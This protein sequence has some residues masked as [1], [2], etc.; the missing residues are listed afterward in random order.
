MQLQR[1]IN[2]DFPWL[3]GVCR[4]WR[5]G[6]VEIVDVTTGKFLS[7]SIEELP[8]QDIC[9]YTDWRCYFHSVDQLGRE[10]VVEWNV[11]GLRNGTR[12]IAYALKRYLLNGGNIADVKHIAVRTSENVGGLSRVTVTV[13]RMR[14]RSIAGLLFESAEN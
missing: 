9:G 13:Y 1:L 2:K 7:N 12:T 3:W 6:R 14:I 10:S 5:V 11:R 8:L 4:D